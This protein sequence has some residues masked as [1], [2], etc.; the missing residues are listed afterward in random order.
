[1]SNGI[2]FRH[3]G[4]FSKADKFFLKLLRKD[5]L[6]ILDQYG[7]IGV[8]TLAEHTP[9]D[10]GKTAASWT[11][12]IVS[13]NKYSSVVFSNTNTNK[14]VNIAIILEYGHGTRNGGYVVG[15]HYIV[16][17]IRPIFEK[18]ASEAWKEVVKT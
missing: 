14:G 7:K 4:D 15:K 1:M 12:E 18:M 3:K 13:N 16:P 2:S 10:T 17:A 5:Y 9:K 6:K 8:E 11:Y